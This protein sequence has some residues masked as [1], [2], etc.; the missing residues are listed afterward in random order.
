MNL[1]SGLI[2]GLIWFLKSIIFHPISWLR[3]PIVL[4]CEVTSLVSLVGFLIGMY[5]YFFEDLPFIVVIIVG[6]IS[7]V[8]YIIPIF[9]DEILFALD[10]NK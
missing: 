9:Y 10:P 4:I 3:F 6:V 1:I 8:F 5:C 2:S 7:F